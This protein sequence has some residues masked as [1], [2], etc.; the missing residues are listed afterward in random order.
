MSYK[1]PYSAYML[2][3]ADVMPSQQVNDELH[4]HWVALAVA[5]RDCMAG[6][7]HGNL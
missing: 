1:P 3:R 2:L 4:H 7:E 5:D 6:Y